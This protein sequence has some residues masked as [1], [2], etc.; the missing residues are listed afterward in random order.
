MQI[1]RPKGSRIGGDITPGYLTFEDAVIEKIF[2]SIRG[3]K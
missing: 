3:T 1:L 2:L